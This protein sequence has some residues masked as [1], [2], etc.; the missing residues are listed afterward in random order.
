MRNRRTGRSAR[1]SDR[2]DWV[3]FLDAD[4]WIPEDLA[5]E[6]QALARIAEPTGSTSPGATSSE[7]K[8]LKHAWWYPDYQL[9]LFRPT[10]GGSRNGSSTS[11]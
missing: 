9:R 1:W 5:S 6:I 4:E 7:G 10:L 8:A 2:F 3:L 11:T